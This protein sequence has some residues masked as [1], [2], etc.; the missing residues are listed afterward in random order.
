MPAPRAPSYIDQHVGRRLKLRRNML[1]LSQ[2]NLAE[3]LGITFQQ[4]QKY[5]NGR[6]RIGAGRL[7]E[8]ARILN[9]QVTFFYEGLVTRP[10]KQTPEDATLQ[11]LLE[12]RD[13]VD[14]AQAFLEIESPTVRRQLIELTYTLGKTAP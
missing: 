4:V 14:I 6:N 2:Q 9:V 3:T 1:S 12:T 7:F 11:K 10:S 8:L 13:G 5:E